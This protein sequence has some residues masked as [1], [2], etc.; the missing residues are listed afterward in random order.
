MA[1]QQ[2]KLKS[3]KIERETVIVFVQ[4]RPQAMRA[5]LGRGWLSVS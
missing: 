2:L 4:Q 3:L 1:S 5:A